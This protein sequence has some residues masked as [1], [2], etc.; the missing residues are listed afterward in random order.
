LSFHDT[1]LV[2]S[3]L[4]GAAGFQVKVAGLSY[5]NSA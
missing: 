3:E 5:I 1:G 2:L 4:L